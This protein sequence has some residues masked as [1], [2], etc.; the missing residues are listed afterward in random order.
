MS[1]LPQHKRSYSLYPLVTLALLFGLVATM[2]AYSVLTVPTAHAAGS[3]P[4]TKSV[5]CANLGKKYQASSGAQ[6]YC[7][8]VQRSGPGATVM[9]NGTTGS[10]VNAASPSED[11]APSGVRAYGQ[12]ETSVAGIGSYV[13][14]A[15]NDA[16]SFFSPCGSSMY[17]EEA[18]GFG[19]SADGGKS[20]ADQGGL[21]NANCNNELYGG[22]PSVEAWQ[23]GGTSYFYVSS[24]Y[25]GVP[26]LTTGFPLD[27]RS[28]IAMAA[29]K[30]TGT[31]STARI[32]C[33]QPIIIGA[34]TQC[35]KQQGNTFCSFLDKDFL[36]I[37]PVHGRL[38][39]T[40]TEFGFN[41][42]TV[43]LAM[44]DIGT[45]SGGTGALGGTAG[46]PVCVNGG[47][48]SQSKT[49]SPYF[50]VAPPD[51]NFCENE[52][53]YP[54]VD[55]R[56]GA[57]YVGYEHNW[58]TSLF[59]F[60]GNTC[61]S[62]PVQNV[63][64][65][66]PFSCLT[67]TTTSQCSGPAAKNTVNVTSM[68]AAFI[69]GYSRFPMSDFPRIAVSRQYGTVSLVWNDARSHVAGD[70][71]MQSFDLVS[72]TNVQAS[73]VR[74]NSSVGGW[75]MLPSVRNANANGTLNIS[76]YNRASVSS[77]MT[78]V[79]AALSVNPRAAGTST[80][81]LVT[82]QAS[83]WLNVSSD[84]NPNFGDYTDNYVIATTGSSFTGTKVYF[85]WSDGRLGVPQPFEA[86]R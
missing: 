35:Q 38:Y 21:P 44:C 71:L 41:G 76:F 10:N 45:S 70:I 14:E 40:Y 57:V 62:L 12:S 2:L 68:Q 5:F 80:N 3:G 72:L 42:S 51:I 84:I 30:A 16:T 19:F 7:N 54:A 74:I 37:D 15:W 73:P 28:Y 47:A 4:S 31:G 65:Y 13:V 48:G 59:A 25:N 52:G 43:E 58:E 9:A 39:A 60:P 50:V 49:T 18:T 24:L 81:T 69:P 27:A 32:S 56:T 64:N 67:L 75:H 53:A 34:S 55:V 36:S 66:V 85:A 1:R 6:M 79:Y 86:Y 78:N 29:C 22:D 17:K 61:T 63:I 8:G 26:S 82:T 46:A 11:V 20:F 23:S 33:S 77:T 83:N